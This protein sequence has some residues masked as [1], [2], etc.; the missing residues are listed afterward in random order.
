MEPSSSLGN[1]NR[2]LIF[3][4]LF[5]VSL[6]LA[7]AGTLA[8]ATDVG[9]VAPRS[10]EPVAAVAAD[11]PAGL[12]GAA[13]LAPPV[14]PSAASAPEHHRSSWWPMRSPESSVQ[15]MPL[16]T[17]MCEEDEELHGRFC[18]KKCSI[19]THEEFPVRA[20]GWSCCRQ[21]RPCAWSGHKFGLGICGGFYVG[22]DRHG[23]GCP[24]TPRSC[25][26]DEEF[27]S[28][29]CYRKCSLLTGGEFPYRIAADTCCKV[30]GSGCSE[31]GQSSTSEAYSLS[32]GTTGAT[33]MA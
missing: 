21:Q 20:S 6:L 27:I 32:E 25:R 15:K 14:P 8:Y 33:L 29:A 26:R 9:E 17:M 28:G 31:T 12:R 23:S 4:T 19:L 16:S 2:S 18:F 10:P 1:P 11:A 3:S 7:L 24:H 13:T 30:S 22:G 5:G